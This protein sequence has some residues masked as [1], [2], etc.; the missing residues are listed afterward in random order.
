[1]KIT[2]ITTV[3]SDTDNTIIRDV[4]VS[5]TIAR[6][7]DGSLVM[8]DTGMAGNSGLMD[9]LDR[10]GLAPEDFQLVINTHLHPDHIGGNRLFD[11][12]RILISRRE[13]RYEEEF[14]RS[15]RD[16]ADPRSALRSLGRSVTGMSFRMAVDM[17]RLA[18]EYPVTALV[19]DPG[20]IEF[21]EDEPRLPA[22]ISFLAVPGHSIASQ[23][24]LIKGRHRRAVAAGDAL[25]HRDW[26]QGIPGL[27]IHYDERQFRQS[28]LELSRLP[29]I[30]IPG[31]DRWFDN[32]HHRYLK[33]GW[34]NLIPGEDIF[35]EADT[36]G[37]GR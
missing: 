4:P 21:F 2:A 10:L 12:A 23:A 8:V 11:R 20:Q 9:E 1:M 35:Q 5:S 14:A 7:E 18:E 25:F 36:D 34:L 22:G 29:D 31:H 37:E 19:G 27:G 33:D 3:V 30:I 32:L 24:V 17:K 28:A 6:L 26:R 15:L 16:C 13:L